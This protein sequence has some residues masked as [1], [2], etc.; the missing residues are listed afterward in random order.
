MGKGFQNFMSKKDF[1]PSAWWNIKKV[2]EAR[3]KQDLEK[4]RDDDMRVQYEKEQEILNNKALLGDE[5][6]RMG[7][8]FMY[9]APAG[10]NKHEKDE[11]N[12]PEPKF[13]WQRKYNAPREEW[14]KGNEAIQDQPFGIQVRNIRCVKCHTWGHLNTDRE[15]PLYNMSGNYEDAGYANNPSELIKQ[16]RKDKVTGVKRERPRTPERKV[17][18]GEEPR[19]KIDRTQLATDMREEHG[20]KFR[21]HIMQSI[22]AEQALEKMGKSQAPAPSE[23]KVPEPNEQK[24]MLQF[25]ET[26]SEKE[27]TK[28]FSEFFEATSGSKKKKKK[29]KEKKV[30][31]EKRDE[32]RSRSEKKAKKVKKEKRRKRH[33]SSN[34]DSDASSV[35]EPPKKRHHAESRDVKRE[36]RS[37]SKSPAPTTSSNGYDANRRIKREPSSS[38]RSPAKSSPPRRSVKREPESPPPSSRREH[39]R[40]PRRRE[41]SPSPRDRRANRRRSR[42]R[43]GDRSKHR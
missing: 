40:E 2:W 14:A 7:L 28:I 39:P 26:L 17:K 9:D 34:S 41:R 10:I 15:C 36:P 42:S 27:R 43:S 18:E 25:L 38:R 3:Q 31:K 21:S 37:R 16:Y 35:S 32:H 23:A 8:S 5:K 33:D 22:E 13:E 1:H 30:K 29:N 20:L 19:E 4:K 6:A 11:E 24:M 12:K